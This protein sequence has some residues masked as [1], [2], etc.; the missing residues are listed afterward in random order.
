MRVPR[1]SYGG[2]G[3]GLAISRELAHLLGGEI[4]LRSAPGTGSTFGLFLPIACVGP[5]YS[6]FSVQ[7]RDHFDRCPA[8][9]A[10]RA[11]APVRMCRRPGAAAARRPD[12]ADR[13]GRSS[14]T[15]GCCSTPRVRHGFQRASSRCAG[16]MRSHGR[17]NTCQRQS[18]SD[19]FLPDMLGWNVLS[20]L[21]LDFS[22]D[23]FRLQILTIE[24]E[25]QHA[26]EQ[27][28]VHTTSANP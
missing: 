21:K 25:R 28:R 22:R 1:A 11:S 4:R 27:R 3:L 2:T 7:T 12:R 20:Q 16:R 14:P 23:T 6:K 10:H 24:E 18:R 15:P 19:V 5:A 9:Q 13:R 26:L 8:T 17:A